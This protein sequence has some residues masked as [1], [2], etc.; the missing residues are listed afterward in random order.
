MLQKIKK[1]LKN[2]SQVLNKRDDYHIVA[3]KKQNK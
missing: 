1:D 2:L 3:R